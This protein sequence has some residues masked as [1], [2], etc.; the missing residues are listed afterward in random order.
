LPVLR[1]LEKIHTIAPG[2]DRQALLAHYREWSKGKPPVSNAHGAFLG[3]VRRFTKNK[4]A[5]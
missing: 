2:W 1:K 3:W 5:A 4:A